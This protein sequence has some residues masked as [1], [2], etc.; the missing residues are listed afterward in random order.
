MEKQ[1]SG[2]IYRQIRR[3]SVAGILV[4]LVLTLGAALALTLVQETSGRDRALSTAALAAAGAP[5]TTAPANDQEA[6][7]YVKMMVESIPDVDLFAYYAADGTPDAFYDK[8]LDASDPAGLSPLDEE[9]M[10]R[11]Q[12]TDDALMDDAPRPRRR[13]PL[14]HC[15]GADPRRQRGG[16]CDGRRLPAF[17]P[18]DGHLDAGALPAGGR[19]GP[20]GGDDAEHAAG[21]PHQDRAAGLRAGRFPGP[22]PA[23]DGASR[24]TGRGA[25]GH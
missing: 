22:V 18:P 11:L 1:P 20:D 6:A 15:G 16:L 19:P 5:Q 4:T 10:Q 24:R 2:G 25:S 3:V 23:P 9:L 12:D 17:H 8:V 7:A 21:P 14:R 13:R